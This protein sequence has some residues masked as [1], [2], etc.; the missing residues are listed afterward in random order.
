MLSC[1]WRFV[2]PW[3]AAVQ[4]TALMYQATAFAWM[5]SDF[6][7]DTNSEWFGGILESGLSKGGL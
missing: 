7:M 1:H 2:L 4:R 3:T 6:A 5:S